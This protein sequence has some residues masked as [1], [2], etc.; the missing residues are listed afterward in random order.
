[1]VLHDKEA[2]PAF[3]GPGVSKAAQSHRALLDGFIPT[4][5]AEVIA[6]PCHL[7]HQSYTFREGFQIQNSCVQLFHKLGTA[8]LRQTSWG[9]RR[10]SRQTWVLV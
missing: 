6:S 4:T 10:E 5:E 7:G 8:S 2:K 3:G 1:M 9:D